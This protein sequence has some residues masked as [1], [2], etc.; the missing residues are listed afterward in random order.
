MIDQDNEQWEALA[1]NL[2]AA[3]AAADGRALRWMIVAGGPGV[4][5]VDMGEGE[6]ANLATAGHGGA[7]LPVHAGSSST[8]RH[9]GEDRPDRLQPGGAPRQGPGTVA[10]LGDVHFSCRT[11]RRRT[12]R[13]WAAVRRRSCALQSV[14]GQGVGGEAWRRLVVRTVLKFAG[15]SVGEEDL[16]EMIRGDG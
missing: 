9:A 10:T 16:A 6:E 15:E 12:T 1:P 3:D 13:T 2:H 8:S 7:A 5:L 11:S 4:G 14:A